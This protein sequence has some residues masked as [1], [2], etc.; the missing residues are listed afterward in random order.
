[1]FPHLLEKTL[2]LAAEI[3]SQPWLIK[4]QFLCSLQPSLIL[5][6]CIALSLIPY[7]M[8]YIGHRDGQL[9]MGTEPLET[10]IMSY[11]FP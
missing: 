3:L 8:D 5:P 9:L 10:E 1:M 4:T 11:P 6:L 7:C 2:A